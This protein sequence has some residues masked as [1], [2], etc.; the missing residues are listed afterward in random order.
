MQPS[1]QNILKEKGYSAKSSPSHKIVNKFDNEELSPLLLDF[2]KLHRSCRVVFN[3]YAKTPDYSFSTLASKLPDLLEAAQTSFIYEA[4]CTCSAILDSPNIA[5]FDFKLP[6]KTT[7]TCSSCRKI[8]YLTA[9]DYKPL[10]RPLTRDLSREVYKV[11]SVAYKAKLLDLTVSTECYNCGNTFTPDDEEN[12]SLRCPAC[13]EFNMTNIVFTPA[14]SLFD[15]LKD[16]QGYW[17]E[18]FVFNQLK[19]HNPEQGI[20]VSKGK[21]SAE[22]DVAFVRNNQLVAVECKDTDPTSAIRKLAFAKGFVD[23]YVL[24][25]TSLT[26]NNDVVDSALEIFGEDRVQLI[27][28]YD[29]EN[30]TRLI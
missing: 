16:H 25:T 20:L 3:A 6:D 15:L 22:L 18:W 30:I 10:F 13:K 28:S 29:L 8:R 9:K 5:A 1:L 24:V 19:K 4:K 21:K 14:G 17:L 23:K 2:L 7:I 26:F 12:V 11:L 27:N